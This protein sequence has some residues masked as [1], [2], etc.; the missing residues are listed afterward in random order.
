[1]A[2]APP[3]FDLVDGVHVTARGRSGRGHD[4]SQCVPWSNPARLAS[5]LQANLP[6]AAGLFASRLPP[7]TG[8]PSF[9]DC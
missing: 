9:T 6:A 7:D 8:S 3:A 1:M 2:E 4:P 5:L